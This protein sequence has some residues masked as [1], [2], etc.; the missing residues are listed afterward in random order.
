M[1]ADPVQISLPLPPPA[2][3]E[4]VAPRFLIEPEPWLRIF[5]RN[6]VDLFRRQRRY[7]LKIAPAP[8]WPDVFV[9][10][11]LPWSRFAQSLILH[12]LLVTGLWALGK[13][14][15][16]R[17]QPFALTSNHQWTILP[18]EAPLPE[19][20]TGARP[21]PP[22]HGDPARA[23]QPI[24]SVPPEADNH[25]QT[26]ITP[27]QLK[28]DSDV[29]LPNIVAWT[30]KTAPIA[31]TAGLTSERQIVAPETA[32]VPPPPQMDATSQRHALIADT[33]PIQPVPNITDATRN[34]LPALA[35]TVIEPPPQVDAAVRRLGD[36]AIAHSEPI[37]PAPQLT[38]FEQRPA[39]SAGSSMADSA[40]R[41]GLPGAVPPPPSVGGAASAASGGRL[42]ALGIH[43]VAPSVPVVAPQGNR[44]GE[45]SAGPEGRA[46]ASG[47]PEIRGTSNADSKATSGSAAGRMIH[48]PALPSGIVVGAA[49][50]ATS[51]GT[52]SVT[53][54][55]TAKIQPPRVGAKPAVPVERVPNAAERRIF[56]DRRFYSLA[57]NM[58]NLNSAG[59]SWIIRFAEL[60][61]TA[62]HGVLL[63]PGITRKVDPSYPPEL[64]HNNVQGTV[65]LYAMI[66]SDGTVGAVRILEGADPRLD[67]YAREA[68]ARCEFQ[69]ALKDGEPVAIEA[70]V[71]IPF[72]L[73]SEF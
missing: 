40:A 21:R 41:T 27:P 7:R 48:D 13:F 49:P 70:V 55:A 59:G 9:Q 10:R 54:N 56:G 61:N 46:E 45:F 50:K 2:A 5:V 33:K 39:N 51:E 65:T 32:V 30:E 1:A 8:F 15:P 29:P 12:T 57:L 17:T 38:V 28:L 66:R 26:I 42:I 37:A 47:V 3:G 36:I 4:I 72:R 19:L 60:P 18:I 69:P 63:A 34:A 24:L 62:E 23:R 16:H 71:T 25:T 68:L 44:R 11:P 43:P 73:R 22:Q 35:P 20:N 53:A 31:P 14:T 52:N 64:R 6:F 58:P 67:R